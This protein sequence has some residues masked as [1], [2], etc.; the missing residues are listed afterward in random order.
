M[1]PFMAPLDITR[2][3]CIVF[4]YLTV[5]ELPLLGEH[6]RASLTLPPLLQPNP[7]TRLPPPLPLFTHVELYGGAQETTCY[8]DTN[9][10]LHQGINVLKAQGFR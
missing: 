5:G 7:S 3:A 8:Y 1:V 9:D 10:P 2:I 4:T 6:L